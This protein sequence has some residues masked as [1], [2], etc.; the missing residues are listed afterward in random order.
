MPPEYQ[1]CVDSMM[2][3]DNDFFV[4]TEW[5]EMCPIEQPKDIRFASD[6]LR[7]WLLSKFS[8]AEYLDADCLQSAPFEVLEDGQVCICHAWGQL[9]IWRMGH[10]GRQEFFAEGF[11]IYANGGTTREFIRWLQSK[12][13]EITLFENDGS[14]KHLHLTGSRKH[15]EA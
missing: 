3:F 14:I 1:Q 7:C 8:A 4:V 9:D 15:A 11:R 13:D 5:S 2:A 12:F 10:N 6:I